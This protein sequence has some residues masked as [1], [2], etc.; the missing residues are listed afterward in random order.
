MKF[1]KRPLVVDA[2]RF[3]GTPASAN[4]VFDE[5]DIPGAKF[6]PT[7][8]EHGVLVIPTLEGSH[9]AAPGDWIIRGGAGEFYPCKPDIFAQTYEPA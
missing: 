4:D 8:V 7:S 1:K 2:I 9:T 6:H 3:N 5:F